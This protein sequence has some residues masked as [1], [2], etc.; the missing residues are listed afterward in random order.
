L[1]Y[2]VLW[3]MQTQRLANLD[4]RHHAPIPEFG[5]ANADRHEA[6]LAGFAD[7]LLAS[8]PFCWLLKGNIDPASREAK[9]RRN[10]LID[11]FRKAVRTMIR[12]E[13]WTSG[14]PVLR[15]IRELKGTYDMRS[16]RATPDN[17]CWRPKLDL[18]DN[19]RILVVSRPGL[20][21]VD[22]IDGY[23][24]NVSR[25]ATE[26]F[27]AQ[28][29]PAYVEAAPDPAAMD[30]VEDGASEGEGDESTDGEDSEKQVEGD[31]DWVEEES[32]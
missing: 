8:E 19:Q 4:T 17:R 2:G 12:C 11:L 13:T 21:Y 32:D 27:E 25:R 14:R 7:N 16:T 26:V 31:D 15:G 20:V 5:R 18:Y 28:V 24:P 30:L 29:I 10:E 9:A 22:S 23:N 6:A 1:T 3:K